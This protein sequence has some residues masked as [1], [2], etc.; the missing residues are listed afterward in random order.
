MRKVINRELCKKI[1]FYLTT[2]WYVYKSESVLENE[3][4]KIF[5]DFETQ[6]DHQPEDQTKWWL[7]KEREREGGEKGGKERTHCVVDFAV[8]AL[9]R[10]KFRENDKSEKFLDLAGELKKK[11]MEHEGDDDTNCNW[12]AWKDPQSFEELE[13][14]GRVKTIQTTALLRSARILRRVL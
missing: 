8:P 1:K 13:I 3:T 4:H 10:V 11:N 7:T 5:G 2:K 12:R 6:T 9:N 14:R